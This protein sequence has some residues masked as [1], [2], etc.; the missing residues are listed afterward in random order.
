MDELRR[1]NEEL[2][3]KNAELAG[4]LQ[5]AEVRINDLI[6]LLNQNSRNSSW[7]SSRDKGKKKRT[8]S[9]R[10]KSDKPVGGQK[11]HEGKT[12]KPNPNPDVVERHRPTAC[13]HCEE[14]LG[15]DAAVSGVRKRQVLELPPLQIV[16]REHQVETVM[17]AGCGGETEGVFPDGV[18]HPVQYD[19]NVKQLAVYLKH[20]QLIPYGREQQL[21][22]DLFDV[23]ISTGSLHNFV[24][25]AG[26]RV[27]LVVE[28]IGEAVKK[29]DVVHADETGFYVEGNRYWLHTA[30]TDEL[31]YY[32]AHKNRG[33][34][35][36]DEIGILPECE[37]TL[38]HDAWATYFK[39]DQADHALCHAHHLRDLT[40]VIENE[41]HRWATQMRALLLA[42]KKQT[43]EARLAG[44][45]A[46]APVQLAE[47]ERQYDTI[48]ADG[49]KEVPLSTKP[50]PTNDGKRQRGRVKKSKSRNLVERFQK[51]KPEML[52]F[53]HDL[54][55]P[56]DNNLA[57]RDIRMMK[58]QQ[59]IS[60]CF[61]S[62]EGASI[63]CKVRSYTA[64][65][66]KQGLNVW[67]AL[68]SLFAGEV[69]K[70][71]LTP[72]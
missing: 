16:T 34:K 11:G 32:E 23:S 29:S 5:S 52:H 37:G 6:G 43:D 7:P 26:E 36:V 57:E 71:A 46:L 56:F 28:E 10:K 18:T 13:V 72:E 8:K 50:P 9:Q 47:L 12:L 31:S 22:S 30:S 67:D 54:T 17:C 45:R 14:G 4:L 69:I 70:P 25:K 3:Q 41:G 65:L 35:A 66:R 55:V 38:V 33:Q 42:T 62:E 61:R 19:A 53:A 2:R 68:G 59:K 40:A 24:K 63:F 51:R 60:G 20:E 44:Q 1:E 48:V 49:L 64:T 21:F 58:V 39:Y 27:E 15:A